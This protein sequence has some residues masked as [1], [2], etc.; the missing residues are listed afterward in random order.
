MHRFRAVAAI[1]FAG[2]LLLLTACDS[3][4]RSADTVPTTVRPP[5]AELATTPNAYPSTAPTS[6]VT[7]PAPIE[8][9]DATVPPERPAALEGPPTEANAEKAAIYFIS[10]FPYAFATGDLGAWKAMSGESCQYC[11]GI[12]GQVRSEQDAGQRRVGGRIEFFDV[13]AIHLGGHQY[14]V[15][16]TIKEHE[17]QLLGADG[18]VEKDTDYV[19]DARM[20]LAV[21][22]SEMG[23]FV[24]G[25]EIKWSG[26]A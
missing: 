20:E 4:T 3:G 26:K 9:F 21:R 15:G 6:R 19:L 23:W 14:V 5:T 24:D 8:E 1:A 7:A 16:A 11:S 25:L 12:A 2:A 17:G 18:S 22:W 13:S 10:L